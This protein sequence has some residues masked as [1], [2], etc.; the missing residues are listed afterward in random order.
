MNCTSSP[1]AHS[2]IPRRTPRRILDSP[3]KLLQTTTKPYKVLQVSQSVNGLIDGSKVVLDSVRVFIDGPTAEMA[4]M[5]GSNKASQQ[6]TTGT[7]HV[8]EFFGEGAKRVVLPEEGLSVDVEPLNPQDPTWEDRFSTKVY[9]N[10]LFVRRCDGGDTVWGQDLQL[11]WTRRQKVE[12][13]VGSNVDGGTKTAT[14]P[15]TLPWDEFDF[16]ATPINPQ[17][18]NWTDT[19]DVSINGN[20]IMIQRTDETDA[21]WMQNLVIAA[22]RRE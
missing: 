11:Q 12:I 4:I 16:S 5:S 7:I 2:P 15:D 22:Y 1:I 9:K 10:E 8:G 20:E 14:L 19:F 13:V 21:A 18:T 17:E 3:S 6:P